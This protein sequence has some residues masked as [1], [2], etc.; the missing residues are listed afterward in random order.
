MVLIEN[1]NKEKNKSRISK[2]PGKILIPC[3]SSTIV[4]PKTGGNN[5]NVNLPFH[6]I[7]N[8]ELNA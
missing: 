1:A 8:A 5:H 4:P 3:A 7:S 6:K 2:V